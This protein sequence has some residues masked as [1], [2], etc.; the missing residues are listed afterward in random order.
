LSKSQLAAPFPRG[1]AADDRHDLRPFGEALV[2]DNGPERNAAEPNITSIDLSMLRRCIEL[3]RVAA[4][5]GEMPFAAIICSDDGRVVS[6][7]PNR[8]SAENDLTRHAELV[9]V[10]AAQ[11]A[12][13]RKRL[14]GH[15]IYSNVEPCVMCS[16]AIREAGIGR[17]VYSIKSPEMGGH[18]RWN[19][20]ADPR[21][22]TRMPIFFQGPPEIVP[23][24]LTEEAE[25]AWSDWNPLVW[26][27]IRMRGIFGQGQ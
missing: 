16:F 2:E 20:L 7:T 24:V 22:S 11:R 3:S 14:H 15:T 8:V 19:V 12:L 9:A 21:L 18:S 17:V 4:A 1:T 5:Q 26:T 23:G 27:L 25:K 10:S 6:E 13:G